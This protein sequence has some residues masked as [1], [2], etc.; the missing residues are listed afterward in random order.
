M[1]THHQSPN[2]RRNANARRHRLTLEALEQRLTLSAAPTTVT[3]STVSP[4]PSGLV[5]VVPVTVIN[6]DD[7][8]PGSLRQLVAANPPG[9]SFT[10][11]P[12]AYRIDLNSPVEL[13]PGD[14]LLS[15]TPTEI[16][17]PNGAFIIDASPS[18]VDAV[19]I[20]NVWVRAEFWLDQQY[21]PATGIEVSAGAALNLRD[22]KISNYD[23]GVSVYSQASLRL[24]G[25]E[26]VDNCDTGIAVNGGTLT[27]DTT[28]QNLGFVNDRDWDS[29]T[30]Y[31]ATGGIASYAVPTL[32]GGAIVVN[33]GSAQVGQ[34]WFYQDSPAIANNGGALEV[35]NS[36]FLSDNASE[37]GTG[38]SVR[39]V[40]GSTTVNTSTFSQGSYGPSI[41]V[42]TLA[43]ATTQADLNATGDTF[44]GVLDGA[45]VLQNVVANVSYTT[46]EYSGGGNPSDEHA[47]DSTVISVVEAD[48]GQ[49]TF[50]N[51]T[52][53]A[54]QSFGATLQYDPQGDAASSLVLVNSGFLYNG[55]G[56]FNTSTATASQ[57]TLVNNDIQLGSIPLLPPIDTGLLAGAPSAAEQSATTTTNDGTITVTVN[58]G[59]T[60]APSTSTPVVNSTTTRTPTPTIA[61]AQTAPASPSS[62]PVT[63]PMA[64]THTHKVVVAKHHPIA[65]Q[66]RGPKQSVH[67]QK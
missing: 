38:G 25:W 64:A 2:R 58:G 54:N 35:D 66:H 51:V 11:G 12:Y 15:D 65:P 63:S 42:S 32:N 46:I 48:D 44:N 3:A 52:F 31:N 45:L 8:G 33:G 60:P 4:P 10:F 36:T 16:D 67:R 9:T 50:N 7:S 28:A 6:G 39:A 17:A 49:N 62:T 57:L 26:E 56:G 61:P 21:V 23:Q 37:G 55:G 19:T 5:A 30:H 24:S 1:R 27:T 22:S 34:A 43:G 29:Y 13:K 53:Y 40:G 18:G 47:P 20:S 41:S 14:V 59:N